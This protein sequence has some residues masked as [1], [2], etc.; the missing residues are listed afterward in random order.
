[1]WAIYRRDMS[2]TA[3]PFWLGGLAVVVVAVALLG[4]ASATA[5]WRARG[6]VE[7]GATLVSDDQ[8]V[9]AVRQLV[10]AVAEAPRDA[11]AHYYLGLAYSGLGQ[12]AAALSH[13]EDAVRLAPRD[14][15]YEA[16]LATLF[17]HA[18]RTAEAVT[19]LRRAVAI[20]PASPDF[21]LLLADALRRAG[22]SDG[23]ERE[24]R[25]AMR[26]ARGETPGALTDTSNDWRR[27]RP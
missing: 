20:E 9:P 18:G 2:K 15:R 8:Y 12:D 4:L 1:M 5:R 10:Q 6:L 23:M 3:R 21:R 14:A 24:Y 27:P 11:R 19:H 13:A 25:I 22:D 7:R 26:L 16:G 17:L